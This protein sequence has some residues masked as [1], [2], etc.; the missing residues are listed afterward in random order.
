MVN[1]PPL[2][3]YWDRHLVLNIL[4][5]CRN[6]GDKSALTRLLDELVNRMEKSPQPHYYHISKKR[7]GWIEDPD[8]AVTRALAVAALIRGAEK[9]GQPAYLNI[10]SDQLK[11]LLNDCISAEGSVKELSYAVSA[12]G[13]ASKAGLS[14]FNNSYE[15]LKRRLWE[16][17]NARGGQRYLEDTLYVLD[18]FHGGFLWYF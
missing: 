12:V 3:N 14:D 13:T 10:A 2:E 8:E 17:L 1:L 9:S 6:D 16:T 11:H 5:V 18:S 15:E 4:E 7:I